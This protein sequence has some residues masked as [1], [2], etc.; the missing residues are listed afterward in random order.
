MP[1]QIR[2]YDH[3]FTKE[4]PN[5]VEEAGSYLDNLNPES[6]SVIEGQGEPSLANASP[7]DRIQFERQGY[8]CADAI[9][10][11]AGRAVFN[12]TATLRDTWARLQKRG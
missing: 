7:G 3:L 2:L 10:H 4:N 12:R 5:E 8:F 1:L 6:I 11:S 9:D